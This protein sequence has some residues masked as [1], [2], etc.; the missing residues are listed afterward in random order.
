MNYLIEPNVIVKLNETSG[1]VR[2]TSQIGAVELSAESSFANKILLYP[3]LEISFST[4]LYARLHDN[5]NPPTE[6][7]VLISSG[8]GGG[9]EGQ[10]GSLIN[11][12]VVTKINGGIENNIILID[13]N[14]K[15]KDSGHKI[16][17]DAEFEAM[18]TRAGLPAVN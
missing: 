14:G 2:N 6:V 3:Y 5:N 9:G 4:Q 11:D 7:Q 18:L 10:E 12:D 13:A 1:T 15:I 16:A 17:T 8:E